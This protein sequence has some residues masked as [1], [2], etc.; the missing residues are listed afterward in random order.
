MNSLE[1]EARHLV[2]RSLIIPLFE[3]VNNSPYVII[4]EDEDT[5]E[6]KCIYC[7]KIIKATRLG[8]TMNDTQW[9]YVCEC[10]G[11]LKAREYLN[12][13]KKIKNNYDKALNEYLDSI[14]RQA[15]P[16]LKDI[17]LGLINDE[18]TSVEADLKER[19]QLKKLIDDL[20][21]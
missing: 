3:K 20:M 19:K 18:I 12:D 21:P 6:M 5:Q 7:H 8:E 4:G 13:L 9:I 14:K 10:D 17:A 16:V 2:E 15:W 11:A 1:Q